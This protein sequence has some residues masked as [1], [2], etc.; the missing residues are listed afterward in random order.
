MNIDSDNS[1]NPDNNESILKP[2]NQILIKNIL[3]LGNHI[4]TTYQDFD[5][6]HNHEHDNSHSHDDS[7]ASH[8]SNNLSGNNDIKLKHGSFMADSYKG[9]ST[10][11]N[12]ST[13]LWAHPWSHNN[14]MQLPDGGAS[15]GSGEGEAQKIIDTK[16]TNARGGRLT[17]DKPGYR[18]YDY[19]DKDI[20]QNGNCIETLGKMQTAWQSA[21]FNLNKLFRRGYY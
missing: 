19:N 13:I 20:F 6:S 8:H 10:A 7:H 12:N 21:L 17:T 16:F 14:Q 4:D 2:N 9:I 1:F 3:G 11:G 5:P 15:T 18:I